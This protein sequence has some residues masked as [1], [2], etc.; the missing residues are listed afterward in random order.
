M[1]SSET[2]IGAQ[3]KFKADAS[4]AIAEMMKTPLEAAE[5]EGG[6]LEGTLQYVKKTAARMA[7]TDLTTPEIW[8]KMV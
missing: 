1:R 6:P 7:K 2:S 8:P 4:E 5:T 3:D